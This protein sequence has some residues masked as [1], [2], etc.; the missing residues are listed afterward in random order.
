VSIS[1]NFPLNTFSAS[2]NILFI[3]W[4]PSNTVHPNCRW[5]HR[6]IFFISSYSTPAFLLACC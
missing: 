6:R 5:W 4:L 1:F 2:I 3:L